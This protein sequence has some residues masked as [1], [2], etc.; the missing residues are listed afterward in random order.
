MKKII[1][2]IFFNFDNTADP[3]LA[4][5]ETWKRELPDFQIMLWDRNNLPLDL[6]E[7]TRYMAENKNHAFLSDYF[8]CWLLN[9]YGGAYFDADIE[10]LNGSIF[11]RT[12]EEAQTAED[13][14][15][16]IG[17]ESDRDGGLTPHSMGI[18]CGETHELLQF[19]MNLYETV[20]ATS[21]RNIIKKFPIPDLMALYFM[22]YEKNE[23][24]TLSKN[25]F[26]CDCTVPFI[27][28]NMKIYPQDYFSP[29]IKY[30]NNMMISAFSKNT[31]LCHHFAATWK[32]ADTAPGVLFSS[33]LK[34]NNYVIAPDLLPAI[35]GQ[36]EL[37]ASPRKPS[38]ALGSGEIAVLEKMLNKL[39]PYGSK[40][41]SVLRKL[42]KKQS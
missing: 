17:I 13:Y 4:Y 29:V 8:R 1:H 23:N 33:L 7:Y 38:W 2:R 18:K 42:R 15:L 16:F 12:Y 28:K 27:T 36:Y 26:F 30:N 35:A 14:T 24:Y 6:N 3:F 41:Y 21:M 9:K 11:R 40:L 31:C 10:V 22:D 25:G 5:L 34:N 39:F 19:L 20:F 32:K 37:P